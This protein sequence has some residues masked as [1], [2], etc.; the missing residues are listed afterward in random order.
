MITENRWNNIGSKDLRGMSR[1]VIGF[2]ELLQRKKKKK[3]ER[4]W[5]KDRR[6]KSK[7]RTLII[8]I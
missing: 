1:L 7:N 3:R 2:K 6:Q 4:L 5:Y 8:R